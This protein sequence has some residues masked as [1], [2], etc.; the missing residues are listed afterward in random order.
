VQGVQP[1][2]K[3]A[4]DAD[5]QTADAAIIFKEKTMKSNLATKIMKE[6]SKLDAEAMRIKMQASIFRKA[7]NTLLGK[8]GRPLKEKRSNG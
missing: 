8:P 4:E 5:A 1:A 2:R 7:A 6:A 3:D